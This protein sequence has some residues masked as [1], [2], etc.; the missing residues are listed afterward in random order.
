MIYD[1]ISLNE[2]LRRDD[3]WCNEACEKF[4]ELTLMHKRKPL[5]ARVRS[6]EDRFNIYGTA[7]PMKLTVSSVDLYNKNDDEV[8][9][10]G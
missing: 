7:C 10:R 1:H 9:Q 5:I 3:Q 8:R 4:S 6:Y 2:I